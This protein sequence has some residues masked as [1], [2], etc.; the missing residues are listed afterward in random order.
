LG[1]KISDSARDVRH[2]LVSACKTVLEVRN[3]S[4]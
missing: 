2:L 4:V 3:R 1:S